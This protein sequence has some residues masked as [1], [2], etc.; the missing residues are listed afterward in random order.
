MINILRVHSFMGLTHVQG[1]MQNFSDAI[2]MSYVLLGPLETN[3]PIT[4][5]HTRRSGLWLLFPKNC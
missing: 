3:I 2:L 5:S 4:S 1:I